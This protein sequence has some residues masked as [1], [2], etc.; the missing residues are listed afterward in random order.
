[1][2]TVIENYL[3]LRKQADAV[4]RAWDDDAEVIEMEKIEF[5][6]LGEY[7]FRRTAQGL[8]F[9]GVCAGDLVPFADAYIEAGKD[10]EFDA[11]DIA[12]WKTVTTAKGRTFTYFDEYLYEVISDTECLFIGLMTT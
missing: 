11:P 1:M 10:A 9:L 8:I 3:K 12:Y 4:R 2:E 7:V 6:Q 5:H